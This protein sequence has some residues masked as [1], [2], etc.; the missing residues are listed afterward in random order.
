[1]ENLGIVSFNLF[2]FQNALPLAS[3]S[4]G[5]AKA[6][7]GLACEWLLVTRGSGHLYMR[8]R[9]AYIVSCWHITHVFF[10]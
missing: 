2:I 9:S 8:L 3:E 6:C 5:A 10:L 7:Q 4:S 1:M